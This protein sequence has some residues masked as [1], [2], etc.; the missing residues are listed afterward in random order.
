MCRA[1]IPVLINLTS[2]RVSYVLIVCPAFQ[3]NYILLSLDRIVLE[4]LNYTFVLPQL[5][6][7]LK[8]R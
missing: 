2:A 5:D 7:L 8:N 3:W 1:T 6:F 4:L